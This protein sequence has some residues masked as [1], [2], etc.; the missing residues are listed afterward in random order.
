M[1]LPLDRIAP[2][3]RLIGVLEITVFYSFTHFIIWKG[4]KVRPTILIIAVLLVGLCVLSNWYHGDSLE[5]IG[6]A[7]RHFWPSLKRTALITGPFFI[8]L[9]LLARGKEFR[10]EWSWWFSLLGYPVWAFAQEYALLG[11]IANRL[12]DALSNHRHMVPWINGL[13]FALVHTPNPAL[14]SVTFVSGVLFTHLFFW[15]RHLVSLAFVHALFGIALNLAFSDI[16]GVM[17]VGPAY[18]HRIGNPIK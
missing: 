2:Y 13:L 12:E 17:S 1:D 9:L 7:K 4:E 14:M 10:T 11:F 8:G 16:N 18:L 3:K 6:L 5:R 15:R